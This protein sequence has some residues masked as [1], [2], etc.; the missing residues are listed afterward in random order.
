MNM[1]PSRIVARRL[2]T[3]FL[4]LVAG[5]S[6]WLAARPDSPVMATAAL[7]PPPPLASL[8]APALSTASAAGIPPD[9]PAEE[10]NQ[11]VASLHATP[12]GDKDLPRVAEYLTFQH[13]AALWQQSKQSGAA[14]SERAQ[15]AHYLLDTLPAHVSRS[16]VTAFE[17]RS[18]ETELLQD[19]ISDPAQLKQAVQ[20]EDQRLLAA[21][22]R[23][24]AQTAA[25]Q[26]ARL[27]S[28]KKREAEVT[29]QWMAMAPASR[30]PKWLESQ[31]DSARQQAFDGGN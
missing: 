31:L 23:P 2:A 20:Q 26:Q 28:Y 16:E 7:S 8:P 25:D 4:L 11:V 17:A 14:S 12:D 21:Q 9:V 3:G 1:T 27:A 13:R 18:L 15:W 6:L 24:D 5:G 10:W 19:S 22:P 30:D 29:A